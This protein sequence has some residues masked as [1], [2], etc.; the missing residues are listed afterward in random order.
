MSAFDKIIGYDHIKAE[1][2]QISDMIHHPE[3]YAALDAK[4]P[5]GLLLSGAPGLGKTLMATALMEDSGLPCFTVRRSQVEDEFLKQLAHTF[6]EAAEAAPSMLL[7]DD[8]DK[9]SSDE[10]STAAFTAVQSCIDKVQEKQVFVIATANNV[11]ELPDSLL[12]CGR[13]T[14]R[15]RYSAPTVRTGSRSS[16]AI[17]PA[18]RRCRTSPCPT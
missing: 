15:S 4:L 6:D 17:F 7:L 5:Q 11:E 10:F 9:F 18:R 13:L 2:M 16:A 14:G 3:V 1:L 8:M 12:R